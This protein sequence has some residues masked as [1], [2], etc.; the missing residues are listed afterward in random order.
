LKLDKV[1]DINHNTKKLIFGFDNPNAVSGLP[2]ASA[3]VT[4]FKGPEDAKPTIR[5]YTPVSDEG[6]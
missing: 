3:L 1:E 5:P 6:E 2:V 4:K